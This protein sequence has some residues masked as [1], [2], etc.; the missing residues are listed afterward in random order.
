MKSNKSIFD[1]ELNQSLK[2]KYNS[3]WNFKNSVLKDGKLDTYLSLKTNFC[4]KNI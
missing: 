2:K 3:D 1:R 4:L